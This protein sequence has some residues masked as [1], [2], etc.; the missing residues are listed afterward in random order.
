VVEG[1]RP[2]LAAPFHGEFLGQL[3]ACEP[4]SI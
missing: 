3:L 1:G 4:E 2:E